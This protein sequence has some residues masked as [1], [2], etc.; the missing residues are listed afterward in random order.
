MI[1]VAS[2]K[3]GRVVPWFAEGNPPEGFVEV[4]KDLL[5]KYRSGEIKDGFELAQ[6]SFAYK[7]GYKADEAQEKPAIKI[8]LPKKEKEPKKVEA[9]IEEAKKVVVAE[10][11][12]FN[13]SLF[14]D[15]IKTRA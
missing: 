8:P 11:R 15:V 6:K 3:D 7:A 12:P 2:S 5:E 14:T 4:P 1:I 9:P 13:A 10:S